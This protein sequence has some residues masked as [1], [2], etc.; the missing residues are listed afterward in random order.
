MTGRPLSSSPGPRWFS[1][2]AHRPFVE[3]LARGLLDALAPLGPE[4]LPAA[5]V[6]T[7]TRRGARALADAFVA[8]GGGKALLLPQI[9]PLGDLDE[10]EPPFE[11]GDLSPGPAAR[12]LLAPPP[13]R[14]GAAGRRQ[15]PSAVVPAP[16]GQALEMA[17]AL[18]DFLDS[19][20][21]EEVVTDDGRLDGLAEGDLAQHWQ[22][23][24]G[25]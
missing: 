17:K 25:S 21:I 15:Q 11:P 19:C 24:A 6:L 13:V 12:R 23:S 5:T 16:A 8:A 20:Q 22:V 9:R 18:A 2:P 1:I 3:D 14:A 10:G 7:P 4:A